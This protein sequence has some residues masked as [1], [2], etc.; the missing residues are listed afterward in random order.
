MR[1][2]LHHASREGSEMGSRRVKG[3][4]SSR[5][6]ALLAALAFGGAALAWGASSVRVDDTGRLHLLKAVGSTLYEEGYA[7]GTLPGRTRVRMLVANSVSA[8]FS[9]SARGGAI[10]GSGHARL[11]SSGRY[12]SFA[13]SLSVSRG[14]GRYARAHGRG[15][16]YG[17]IDRRSDAVTVQTIGTLE[18]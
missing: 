1:D 4:H 13:G 9:I 3:I 5:I 16:L 6:G 8:S 17:V 15:K 10:Y 18:Y 11:H 7:A 14:S 12:A 2:G